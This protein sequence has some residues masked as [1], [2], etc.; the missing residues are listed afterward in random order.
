MLW[1]LEKNFQGVHFEIFTFIRL[2]EIE[3]E[4]KKRPGKEM[5]VCQERSLRPPCCVKLCSDVWRLSSMQREGWL[6]IKLYLSYVHN[7]WI[8]STSLSQYIDKNNGRKLFD[9]RG[10]S[11]IYRLIFLI[12]PNLI[13]SDL[14][15]KNF[16]VPVVVAAWRIYFASSC[17]NEDLMQNLNKSIESRKKQKAKGFIHQNEEKIWSLRDDFQKLCQYRGVPWN[18][19]AK[20]WDQNF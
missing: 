3:K 11:P 14:I 19:T 6:S 8:I 2:G 13:W 18:G 4:R 1:R 5:Q 15:R 9:S 20:R 16:E 10:T 7:K 12:R 17:P